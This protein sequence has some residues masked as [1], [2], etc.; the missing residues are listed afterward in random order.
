MLGL[1]VDLTEYGTALS[2]RFLFDGPPPFEKIFDDYGIYLRALLGQ[3]E[4]NQA[5]AVRAKMSIDDDGETRPPPGGPDRGEPAGTRQE[6]LETRRVDVA[7]GVSS[8]AFPIPLACPASP[9]YGTSMGSA[10]GGL[11]TSHE[12]RAIWSSGFATAL[13]QTRAPVPA[14]RLSCFCSQPA[15]RLGRGCLLAVRCVVLDFA[16]TRLGEFEVGDL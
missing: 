12:S 7:A 4:V 1:A 14:V 16:E 9:N 8:R 11:R 13:L 6:K 10:P 5:I 3:G 15:E 2:P